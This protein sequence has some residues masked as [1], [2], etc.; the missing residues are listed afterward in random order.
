MLTHTRTFLA[1]SYCR[2]MVLAGFF[3]SLF[4]IFYGAIL[5]PIHY[6]LET[7]LK[8]EGGW[9]RRACQ[10]YVIVILGL[11]FYCQ[12]DCHIEYITRWVTYCILYSQNA[13]VL[14]SSSY[15]KQQ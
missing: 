4:H 15:V 2:G 3:L 11:S 6:V 14:F 12:W 9:W 7:F 8:I 10:K 13:F 1:Q 5:I